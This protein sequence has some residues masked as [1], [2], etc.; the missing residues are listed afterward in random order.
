M[1]FCMC[2]YT[3]KTVFG[4]INR[5]CRAKNENEKEE[6]IKRAAMNSDVSKASDRYRG[7]EEIRRALALTL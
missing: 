6:I 4:Q 7:V 5:N 3:Q 2:F 1:F